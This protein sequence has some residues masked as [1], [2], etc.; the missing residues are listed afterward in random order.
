MDQKLFGNVVATALA[1]REPINPLAIG[2]CLNIAEVAAIA[3]A[4]GFQLTA[5]AGE[6]G[7]M[8]VGETVGL[9]ETGE[10]TAATEEVAVETVAVPTIDEVTTARLEKLSPAFREVVTTRYAEKYVAVDGYI[11]RGILSEDYRLPVLGELMDR[12]EAVALAYD[13]IHQ[14][15]GGNAG[16]DFAPQH[17]S[18][19]QKSQLSAGHTLPNGQ[20]TTGAY[21]YN[22]GREVTDP[23]NSP[24]DES[25]WDTAVMDVS[26]TPETKGISADGSK[27]IDSV[28]LQQTL[29]KFAAFRNKIG[30][31]KLGKIRRGLGISAA[32]RLVCQVSPD[33][34][35]KFGIQLG[36]LERGEQEQ[37]LDAN[38]IWTIGKENV[39]VG[40]A[41]RS[42]FSSFYAGNRRLN[43]SS[44]DRGVAYD[45]DV[46]RLSAR[47]KDLIPRS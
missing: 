18:D 26:E 45:D 43:S 21:N 3:E 15:T 8:A 20:T 6:A 31:P 19:E 29:R 40:G 47:G 28:D 22:A 14:A 35:T 5:V 9:G 1:T 46:V 25:R 39:K 42:V 16:F 4:H 30:L 27:A 10:T 13:A 32:E 36:R 33:E 7:T 17:L 12:V 38:G 34:D 11:K 37:P 23:T 41:L 2:A 24:T 44:G